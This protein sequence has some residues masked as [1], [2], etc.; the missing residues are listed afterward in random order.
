MKSHERIY[1]CHTYYHVYVTCLK[2]LALPEQRRG[3]A[4]LVLSKMSTR[5]MDLPER[6]RRCGL[7][8]DVVEFDEKD[9]PY[10]PE[11]LELKKDTGFLPANMINRI[12]FCRRLGALEEPFVPVDFSE[13]EDIYVFCDS[14][15]V[16]YYLA[17]KKL[18]Y[19]AVEDGLNC[20]RYRDT[21]RE[22]NAGHFRLK[23]LMAAA[24][25]IFIQNGYSRY[26]IDMEVNDL[27]VLDHP[28]PKMKECSREALTADLTGEQKELLMRLF[29]VDEERLMAALREAAVAGRPVVLILTEPL[30]KDL[31]VRQRLFEDMIREYG[32]VDGREAVIVIKPHPRD[33]LDYTQTFSQHI[34][35]DPFFPMEL[36]N[37]TGT[38]FDRVVTVYTVPSSIHCAKEKVYLGNAFMDR[39]EDSAAHSAVKNAQA[40][41]SKEENT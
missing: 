17:W 4:T 41:I 23:A 11:L 37:F 20:I 28:T 40:R 19:H 32:T 34:V 5:F 38:E 16:G 31:A 12:R 25:L 21:A 39:Y 26:C 27:S 10:F 29:I 24:G 2:E 18:R 30:C 13:Y 3:K 22:D 14:D 9:F 7:F 35:L 8:E 1:V 15:P 6:A 36:L 33:V